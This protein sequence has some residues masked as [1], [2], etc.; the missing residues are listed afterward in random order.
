MPVTVA[1]LQSAGLP[2]A[3]SLCHSPVQQGELGTEIPLS[4]PCFKTLAPVNPG[5]QH[6]LAAVPWDPVLLQQCHHPPAGGSPA[7][8]MVVEGQER[9]ASGLQAPADAAAPVWGGQQPGRPAAPAAGDRPAA[10]SRSGVGAAVT[11]QSTD[12]AVRSNVTGGSG[13]AAAAGGSPGAGAGGIGAGIGVS[14]GAKQ[15]TSGSDAWGGAGG[16]RGPA[17]A[18]SSGGTGAGVGYG[19]AAGAGTGSGAGQLSAALGTV[20]VAED[21]M[22]PAALRRVR[23]AAQQHAAV[24]QAWHLGCL[25]LL[26]R[27]LSGSPPQGQS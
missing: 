6:C 14:S 10:G 27:L 20:A 7:H 1:P 5:R 8:F 4:V 22:G 23:L 26:L 16:G 18:G 25:G 9:G 15:N 13:R 19:A 2:A 24:L 3:T 21:G 12:P 17:P 11:V